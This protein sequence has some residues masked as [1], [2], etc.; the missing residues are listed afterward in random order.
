MKGN[1]LVLI[2]YK[3]KEKARR[4]LKLIINDNR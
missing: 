1:N 4:K 2:I 3:N